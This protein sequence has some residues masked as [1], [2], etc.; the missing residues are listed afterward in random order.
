MY[1][2]KFV[3]VKTINDDDKWVNLHLSAGW[4]LLNVCTMLV[5][6]P[7]GVHSVLLGWPEGNPPVHPSRP[8][9]LDFV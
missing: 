6:E 2:T 1:E 5:E 7:F 3:E 9:E 8:S 4:V